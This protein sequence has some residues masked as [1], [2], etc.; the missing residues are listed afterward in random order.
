[1]KFLNK[2]V[3]ESE[4]RN[5]AG[6]FK[7]SGLVSNLTPNT[8]KERIVPSKIGY[9]EVRDEEDNVMGK[10]RISYYYVDAHLQIL[11]VE[12]KDV[13]NKTIEFTEK[14]WQYNEKTGTYDHKKFVNGKLT[15]SKN[16]IHGYDK[17]EN[18]AEFEGIQDDGS[19]QMRIAADDPGS[20]WQTIPNLPYESCCMFNDVRYN[21]CGAGC[22]VAREDGGGTPVNDCDE[23][24][25]SHDVCMNNSSERCD[26]DEEIVDCLASASCPGDSTMAFGIRQAARFASCDYNG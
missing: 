23:C 9:K 3:T 13:N 17:P 8:V 6:E 22:G 10:M 1:M 15:K 12:E 20:C 2:F 19:D 24:C 21:Y 16:L 18:I 26:C 25:V 11:V 4:A 7:R 14:S 5:F